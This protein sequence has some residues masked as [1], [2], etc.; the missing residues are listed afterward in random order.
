MAELVLFYTHGLLTRHTPYP[1][2][3]SSS[4]S[5]H[6]VTVPAFSPRLFQCQDTLLCSGPLLVHRAKLAVLERTP[7]KL[8]IPWPLS[9]QLYTSSAS[10]RHDEDIVISFGRLVFWFF[11]AHIVAKA[12]YQSSASDR[13]LHKF[14]V[15]NVLRALQGVVIPSLFGLYRNL[16]DGS[17]MLITSYAGVTLKDFNA[18]CL[19]DRQILLSHVIQL[20][21]AGVQH[22]DLEPRNVTI[23]QRSGPVIIDF[24]N[25][26]LEHV[27]TG[28]SCK[29][30]SQLSQCLGLELRAELSRPRRSS[31]SIVLTCFCIFL[32]LLMAIC[33]MR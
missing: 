31:S 12:A 4:V 32:I 28:L 23:S 30:L 6:R 29:E 26:T 8:L 10:W 20:H 9:V 2:S 15:Y 16:D 3:R 24:D 13:L 25:A 27:C 11:E 14:A 17:S 19:R 1:G 22:N 33:S 5:V 18:L 7:D 21:Q